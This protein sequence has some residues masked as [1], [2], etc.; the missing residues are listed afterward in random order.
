MDHADGIVERVVIDDEPRMRR[1]SRT[2]SAARRARCPAAP[3]RCRRAAPSRPRSAARAGQDVLQHGAFL[4]RE[5]GLAGAPPPARP[6][7]RRGSS[8]ACQPNSVR[9]AQREP[10]FAGPASAPARGTGTGRLRGLARGRG[11][12]ARAAGDRNRAWRSRCQPSAV[13]R[14]VGIGHSETRQNR[15]F[16]PLHGLGFVVRS[17]DRSRARCRK[18]CTARCAR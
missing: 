2:P 11:W 5:A 16:E 7:D 13:A 17:R 10:A 6:R 9:S 18:P 4:R 8:S 15:G 1:R 3:R 12:I 14:N